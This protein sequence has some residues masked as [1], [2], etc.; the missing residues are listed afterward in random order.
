MM[1]WWLRALKGKVKESRIRRKNEAHK[2][3]T[4]HYYRH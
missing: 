2:N 4:L 1:E 3:P